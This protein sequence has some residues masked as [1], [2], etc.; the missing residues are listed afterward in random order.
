MARN[1]MIKLKE[2]FNSDVALIRSLGD[3]I[4]ASIAKKIPNQKIEIDFSDIRSISRAFAHEILALKKDPSLQETPIEF[5]NTSPDI[6][7]LIAIVQE[8]KGLDRKH[9]RPELMPREVSFE[10][11]SD[12]FDDIRI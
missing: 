7:R 3:V 12:S 1:Y 5:S 8:S 9:F 11:A 6:S 4:R 10:E 2:I